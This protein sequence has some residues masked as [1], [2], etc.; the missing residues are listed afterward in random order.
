M[1]F[2]AVIVIATVIPASSDDGV[3]LIICVPLSYDNQDGKP[4]TETIGAGFPVVVMEYEYVTPIIAVAEAVDVMEG[5]IGSE[6]TIEN[7]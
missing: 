4:L 1:P 5:A 3:P 7:V 2:D 6:T